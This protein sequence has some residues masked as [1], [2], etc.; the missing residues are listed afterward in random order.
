MFIEKLKSLLGSELVSAS[1][2]ELYRHSKDESFH[3]PVEPDIICFPESTDDV[4]KIMQVAN[5]FNVSVTPYGAGS[6][7]EGQAIPVNKGITINFERM[8]KVIDFSP[9][10]L[11]ITIQ[12]GITRSELNEVSNRQGLIFPIDPGA[13]ATIGGMVATNASG[14]TAVRYGS[15]RDQVLDLEIVLASGKVIRTGTKAKKSSS[16]YHLS[17]LFTGSEGTLGI[18][19]GISLRLHGIPEHTIAARCTF[20]TLSACAEAAQ[21]IL[22]C[23]IQV[24]RMELVDDKSIAAVN[25]YGNYDIPVAHSLF[26]EFAGTKVGVEEEAKL[27]EEV[28]RELGCNN[29]EDASTSKERS[30]LWTARHEIAYAY[31]H[32]KG[33]AVTGAD[34]CVPISKLPEMVDYARLLIEESGLNGGILGHVGD[35]NFH[36]L[37]S[38]NPT[39]PSEQTKAEYT[40]EALTFRAIE[41][42][43]TC[44]GEHGVGLGKR[45]FQ[46]AEHGAA[47]E[48]MKD[49]KQLLDPSNLL[50]P[51]KIFY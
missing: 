5:E 33:V 18:I 42:G 40:N 39:I 38:F 43:G 48:V 31:R 16:G 10:D 21:T 49:I 36:T 51:G 2:S 8:N 24:L 30:Q 6:G 25:A 17:G 19:T 7:L 41:L 27:A 45:K 14:T 44:T 12:P 34:V 20:D 50:N 37:V 15:M 28:M 26:F 4:V 29:W 23:G 13:D 35:G 1:E 11:T 9:E 3:Q 22:Q 47:I 46:E 32:V